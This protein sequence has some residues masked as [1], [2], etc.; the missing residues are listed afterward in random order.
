M[1]QKKSAEVAAGWEAMKS[2]SFKNG[3]WYATQY[4]TGWYFVAA[5]HN[6]I[7]PYKSFEEGVKEWTKATKKK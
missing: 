6:T 2:G 5:D 4:P 1:A 3:V 7:G